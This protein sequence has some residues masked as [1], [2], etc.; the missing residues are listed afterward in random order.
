MH[1]T[2]CALQEHGYTG[3]SIQRIADE[4]D[5]SKST[6]YH[7]FENKEDLLL[8]FGDFMLGEFTR[9]LQHESTGDPV[10]DL[11]TF[12]ALSMWDVPESWDV[13]ASEEALSTYIEMRA[14]AVRN[15]ELREKFTERGEEFTDRLA[16]I[17]ETGI[18]EGA[19]ADVDPKRT[20][21]FIHA[22]TD[23]SVHL[24]ATRADDPL[25]ELRAAIED[26]VER[27]VLAD[28]S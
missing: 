12:I 24:H 23:G 22:F 10:T 2:F 8:S 13:P 26:Y 1:A 11:Y 21:M 28:E 4:A 9:I 27:V 20:A 14:Q 18:E 25:P 7:H 19:F 16:A 6:F 17:I 15:E 5:L 3:L